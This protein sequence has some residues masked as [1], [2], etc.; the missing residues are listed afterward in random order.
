ME[1]IKNPAAWIGF[2]IAVL[3]LCVHGDYFS[4]R[5][6][7]ALTAASQIL[8]LAGSWFFGAGMLVRP[9]EKKG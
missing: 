9:E 5:V 6:D 7:S 3:A 2:L 4:A 8:G 1:R